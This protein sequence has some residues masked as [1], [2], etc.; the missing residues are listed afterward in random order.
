[1]K[2]RVKSD[3]ELLAELNREKIRRRGRTIQQWYYAF[4][5]FLIAIGVAVLSIWK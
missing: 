1:M 5:F 3:D 4:L 2:F